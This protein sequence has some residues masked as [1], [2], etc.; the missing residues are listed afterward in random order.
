M[1]AAPPA[2]ARVGVV[3]VNYQSWGPLADNLEALAPATGG[4]LD[5]VVVDNDSPLDRFDEFVARFPKVAFLRNPGNPGF[6]HGSNRGAARVRGEALIFLNPDA[7]M[8]P[9]AILELAALLA[10]DPRYGLLSPRIEEADGSRGRMS[11]VYPSAVTA[12]PFGRRYAEARRQAGWD[13][14][15]TDAIRAAD[16]VS[17]AALM[18]GR[19]LFERLGG[20]S[21][22]FW[23]YSEDIDLCWRVREA[24]L[25]VGWAP[26]VVARHIGGQSS[27]SSEDLAVRCRTALVRARHILYARHLRG[28]SALLAHLFEGAKRVLRMAPVALLDLLTL[29]RRR[30]WRI[31]RRAFGAVL[32]YYARALAGGGAAAPFH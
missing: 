3:I 9:A 23:L 26:G 7:R 20:W 1:S 31:R 17:G 10:A 8:A 19:P 29:G 14:A 11:E 16:W 27:G 13:A 25:E 15:S 30:K 24:G 6:A 12:L 2:A 32:R 18:I 5:V 21:E 4:A 22:E 28:G